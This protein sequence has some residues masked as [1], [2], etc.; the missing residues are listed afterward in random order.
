MKLLHTFNFIDYPEEIELTKTRKAKYYYETD[1]D[2]PQK[3]IK[4]I[5]VFYD[6]D[7]LKQAKDES[8]LVDIKTGIPILRNA[9]LVNKPRT[10]K[11]AGQ[12]LHELRLKDYQRSKILTVLKSYFIST[13]AKNPVK[14]DIDN[15]PIF[16]ELIFRVDRSKLEDLDNYE[17]FYKKTLFDCFV[18][19]R[20]IRK[21]DKKTKKIV[22]ESIPNQYG[23]LTDDNVDIIKGYTVKYKSKHP[24]VDRVLIVK[25]YEDDSEN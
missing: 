7:I 18:K 6:F 17:L 25:I 21:K 11:I 14:I 1:E 23:F 4:N 13:I 20:T 16:I 2:I 15:K 5:G 24:K 22:F 19:T 12:L 3:Y 8:V 10:M 9:H